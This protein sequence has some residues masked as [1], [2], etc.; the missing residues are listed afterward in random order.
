MLPI[1]PKYYEWLRSNSTVVP[2]MQELYKVVLEMDYEIVLLSAAPNSVREDV[3]I[4]LVDA[5]YSGWKNI[6]LKDDADNEKSIVEFKSEKSQELV[7]LRYRIA[8]NV[9][10]QWS[11]L[12]GENVG[13]R[14]FKVPN[15]VYY[16]A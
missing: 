10:D 8:G 7:D 13:L 3:V 14:T 4:A 12:T 5:G 16:K 1:G 9:G 6:I 11:D 2:A 15:P